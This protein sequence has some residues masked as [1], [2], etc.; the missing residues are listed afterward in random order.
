MDP[1]FDLLDEVRKLRAENA[2][3]REENAKLRGLGKKCVRAMH[4]IF[5][6]DE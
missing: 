3:L 4:P 6:T 1:R 2:R 5:D